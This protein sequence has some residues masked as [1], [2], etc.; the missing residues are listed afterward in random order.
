LTALPR[1]CYSAEMFFFS[2]S[3]YLAAVRAVA[4]P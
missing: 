2:S 1:D 3:V 4:H